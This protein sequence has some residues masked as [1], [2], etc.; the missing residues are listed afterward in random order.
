M[1]FTPA[2]NENIRRL[3]FT[4]WCLSFCGVFGLVGRF[5]PDDLKS[6]L[7]TLDFTKAISSLSLAVTDK[8]SASHR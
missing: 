7:M 5:K 2:V 3:Y 4:K 8:R 1:D 6:I